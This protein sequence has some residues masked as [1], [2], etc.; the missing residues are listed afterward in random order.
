M[1][2]LFGNLVFFFPNYVSFLAK[3]GIIEAK[4]LDGT[5]H[6]SSMVTG[7]FTIGG[8]LKTL[9]QN[10]RHPGPPKLRVWYLD[11][12]KIPKTPNLRDEFGCFE[13]GGISSKWAYLY[14]LAGGFKYFLFSPL[15]GEGF[16]FD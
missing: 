10:P 2:D 16:H 6:T 14:I 7:G 13:L 3:Y 9:P 4:K 12:K 1:K 15:L 5:K 11:H 8:D